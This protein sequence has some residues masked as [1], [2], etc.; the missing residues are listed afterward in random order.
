MANPYK[1]HWYNRQASHWFRKAPDRQPGMAEHMECLTLAPEGDAADAPA[2]R[3]YL[4]TEPQQYRA[5][6][7]FVWSVMKYRNPARAYEIY[8]MSDLGGIDRTGWKTGFTNYRYAIPHLAGN[9]GRGIYNDVDQIY[10]SDPALLFDMDMA[11]KGVLAISEKENSVMLIDC[12]RMG[13]L[14]TLPD[15]QAGHKHAHFKSIMSDNDLLGIMPGTW[16]SRDGEFPIEQTDCLHYTTLH[17]QPWR[18]FPNLLKYAPNP[19]GQVWHD[20]E[21]EADAAGF[22]LFTA[23]QPSVAFAARGQANPPAADPI[24]GPHRASIS[25]LVKRTEATS[26]LDCG[27]AGDADSALS[28]RWGGAPPVAKI[29]PIANAQDPFLSLPDAKADGVIVIDMLHRLPALDV[30]WV[31]DL[32]FERAERFVFLA[33]PEP[34]NSE[35]PTQT[36]A[37]MNWWHAQ[38]ALAGRRYPNVCWAVSMPGKGLL[39]KGQSIVDSDAPSPLD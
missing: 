21:A 18:P 16:N 23:E 11:G 39:G 28:Q 4:G 12:D 20:L 38:L 19:F 36:N 15:V 34:S 31:L 7:V 13:P 29:T 33:L 5:T 3:I 22:L 2:V 24:S 1:T 32:L 26:L 27:W 35:D 14:W 10:L 8:L 6:R 37:P 25:D 30:P 9:G 17:M